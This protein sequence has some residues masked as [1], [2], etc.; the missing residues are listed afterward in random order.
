MVPCFMHSFGIILFLGDD[1]VIDMHYDL[2]HVL[3]QCYLRDDYTYVEDWIKSYNTHNVSGVI[4]NLYFMNTEEM[5]EE[6]GD[7]E[8]N[9]LEMFGIQKVDG[10]AKLSPGQ[11]LKLIVKDDE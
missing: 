2:L 7:I 9:V 11:E 6:F 3:Y 10:E 1:K 4:A 5:R 8:I